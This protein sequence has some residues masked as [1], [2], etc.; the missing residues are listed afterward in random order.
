MHAGTTNHHTRS[1][2]MNAMPTMGDLHRYL[3]PGGLLGENLLD[4]R[5]GGHVVRAKDGL[6]FS[7]HYNNKDYLKI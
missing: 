2:E 3:L 6:P 7:A 1:L 4:D 5:Y